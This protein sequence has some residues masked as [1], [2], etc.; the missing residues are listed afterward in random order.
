MLTRRLLE[1]AKVQKGQ[2]HSFNGKKYVQF[3]DSLSQKN[4]HR[5]SLKKKAKCECVP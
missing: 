3:N 2:A 4:Q 5:N 1:V